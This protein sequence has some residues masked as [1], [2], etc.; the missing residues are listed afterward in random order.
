[1]LS[2]LGIASRLARCALLL[3]AGCG[4]AQRQ[5]PSSSRQAPL[6]RED[7]AGPD[8]DPRWRDR[9]GPADTLTKVQPALIR[10]GRLHLQ[11]RFNH[12]VWLKTPLPRRFVLHID[13]WPLSAQGDA[14]IEIAGDGHSYGGQGDYRASGYVLIFGGWNGSRHLIARQDEHGD[15]VR[16]R[17]AGGIDQGRRY[18]VRIERR[19]ASIRWFV[20]DR[21]LLQLRDDQPLHGPENRYLGLS[22]YRAPVAFD[23]LRIYPLPRP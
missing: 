3:A 11:D 4:A 18:H 15:D 9:T 20:D 10:K 21:L 23:A 22:A 7:F 17:P 12:P 6:L 5:Y 16:S 2:R 13:L 19:D 1:M 14:K 8:L